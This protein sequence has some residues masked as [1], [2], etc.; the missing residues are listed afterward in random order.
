MLRPKAAQGAGGAVGTAR[1]VLTPLGATSR[2]TA[3]RLFPPPPP[4]AFLPAHGA[5]GRISSRES[6]RCRTGRPASPAA[7]GLTALS[8]AERCWRPSSAPAAARER[9]PQLPS[10]AV[11]SRL[12]ACCRRPQRTYSTT[13]EAREAPA[14]SGFVLAI[15]TF[16][17]VPGDKGPRVELRL[18]DPFAA[19][20]HFSVEPPAGKCRSSL[21]HGGDSSDAPKR[22]TRSLRDRTL[23]R[24]SP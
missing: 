17:P 9:S 1:A 21:C 2:G 7:V 13:P 3:G 4:P 19:A 18:H 6:P 12:G 5:G 16:R 20:H 11:G 24:T 22:A 10:L 8:G 15:A 14:G 23:T